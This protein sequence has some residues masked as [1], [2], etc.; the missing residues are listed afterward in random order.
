M[1]RLSRRLLLKTAGCSTLAALTMLVGCSKKDEA[2]A[3]APTAC[4][5]LMFPMMVLLF[6]QEGSGLL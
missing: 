2:P 6:S 5:S 3:A 1:T 4:L